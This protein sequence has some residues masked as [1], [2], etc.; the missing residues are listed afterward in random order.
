MLQFAGR[1]EVTDQIMG[2]LGN[3]R[4]ADVV[5]RRPCAS[6]VPGDNRV[7]QREQSHVSEYTATKFGP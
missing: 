1:I 7:M 6:K 4:I 2:R 5:S 3:Q